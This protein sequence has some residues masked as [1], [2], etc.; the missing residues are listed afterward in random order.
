[1]LR[2]G[3]DRKEIAATRPC[4]RKRNPCSLRPVLAA[5]QESEGGRER[6]SPHGLTKECLERCRQ[7]AFVRCDD[8]VAHDGDITFGVMALLLQRVLKGSTVLR[9]SEP[10]KVAVHSHCPVLTG[11]HLDPRRR[12]VDAN[13]DVSHTGF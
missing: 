8:T 9:G 7:E 6:E 1:M 13:H 10:V 5:A 4:S 11:R 3:R 2:G 12:L